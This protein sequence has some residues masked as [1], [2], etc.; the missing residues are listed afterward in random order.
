ME[1]ITILGTG[2]AMTTKCYNTCFTISNGNEHFL[3]DAGGGNTILVNLEKSNININNIKH[4]FISHTHGDHILGAPWVI[5]AIATQISKNLYNGHFTIYGEKSVLKSL[6]DICN[7]VL[8]KQ[9]LNM[10]GKEI[11]FKE[12]IDNQ[13][14]NILGR[15]TTFFDIHSTKLIQFGFKTQ[16]LNAKTLTFLGDEPFKENLMDFCKNTNYLLHEAFCLYSDVDKFKPYEKH[17][18]TVKDAAY[19][20]SFLNVKNLILYHSE[21]KNLASRQVLYTK[22]ASKEFSG[23]IFVPND[24]DIIDLI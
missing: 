1:K 8:K 14:L 6:N 18:V 12:I 23:N 4:M 19:N 3:V 13:T 15:K 17:H 16:L 10:F 20:A 5:R 7:I 11:L 21:D 22:E 2:S 9:F 24:L